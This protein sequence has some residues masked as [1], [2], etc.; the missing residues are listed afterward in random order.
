[1]LEVRGSRARYE[2]VEPP[3]ATGQQIAR[4]PAKDPVLLFVGAM[5]RDVNIDAAEWF[6][7][8]IWPEVVLRRPT[9]TM[10]IVG[11]D[12]GLRVRQAAVASEGVQVAGF[13]EDLSVEYSR[14]WVTVIPL[15]AGAGVKFKTI[16]AMLAGVPVV[17]TSIGAEGIAGAE[18]F[19]ALADD[20]SSFTD[21]VVSAIDHAETAQLQADLTQRWATDRY[22]AVGIADRILEIYGLEKQF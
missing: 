15:L 18:R 3:L 7:S 1:M 2:V 17:T 14:A 22:D 9:A 6:L 4:T 5:H 16:E 13:V 12:P 8:N 10:R 21:G 20:V 11:D 19:W